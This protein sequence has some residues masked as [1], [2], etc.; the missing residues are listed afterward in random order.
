M[1]GTGLNLINQWDAFWLINEFN[2]LPL[3]LTYL[4]PFCVSFYSSY[5]S[6]QNHLRK[7]AVERSNLFKPSEDVNNKLIAIK[8]NL[9]R[10]NDYLNEVEQ[11]ADKSFSQGEEL[12]LVIKC[13][14]SI[15]NKLEVQESKIDGELLHH[16]RIKREL[17]DELLIISSKLKNI[18]ATLDSLPTE[19]IVVEAKQWRKIFLLNQQVQEQFANTNN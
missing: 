1:V 4:V 5:L 17:F 14:S 12:S 7:V 16:N 8:S 10:L 9:E 18:Q 13:L 11:Y 15:Q 19:Y 2:L 3:G 6:E